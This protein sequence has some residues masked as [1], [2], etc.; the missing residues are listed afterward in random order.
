VS[1]VVYEK[2][3]K[4]KERVD[5]LGIH[6]Y[7]RVPP[8]FPIMGDCGAFG[9]IDQ[10]IPPYSTTEV[11]DYYTRLGFDLG[12]SIDH[13]IV[14][15]T[16]DTRNERYEL[17]IENAAEF[18]RLHRAGQLSWEPVGS[19]QGWD[20]ASYAKAARQYASMGYGY[21]ALGGLVRTPTA[22]VLRIV[23]AV[24]EVVP[25]DVQVHLFGL[26]RLRE[27][28]EMARLG[29]SSVDSA[30]ALRRAWL[31]SGKNYLSTRG[32]WFSAIRIPQAGKSFRAKRMVV[33]GR[34]GAE[35]V[36]RLEEQCLRAMRDF[37]AGRISVD[38]AVDIIDEYD[39]LI[40]PDRP[41]NRE[42]LARTL[43][44]KP[45]KECSCAVCDA[46]G[47]EVIIF[48]GNNRNRRRGFH[49]TYVFSRLLERV[50]AGE[51]PVGQ[52]GNQLFM[53]SK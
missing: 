41:P 2:S 48:R 30:S 34:A 8:E 18:I 9:Y 32:E 26:A 25:R 23:A 38:K 31:G 6:R 36:E 4:K 52:G 39:R 40:T 15:S 28:R 22:E 21:I 47:I 14:S 24:R 37:D 45:W 46:I 5:A 42:H 11:L 7:L 50:L 44:A 33:E 13:L 27:A 3:K 10:P 19:V 53:F 49:N 29:V 35:V 1:R 12:V 51:D 17:T 16:M 43:A 20:P